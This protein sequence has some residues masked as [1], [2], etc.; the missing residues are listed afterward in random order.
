M[1]A[2]LNGS[3]VIA[4][5]SS[6]GPRGPEWVAVPDTVDI[7]WKLSGAVLADAPATDDATAPRRRI[8]S[9]IWTD[10]TAEIIE[11]QPLYAVTATRVQIVRALRAGGLE[12]AFKDGLAALP[13]DA[14][15]DWALAVEISSTD[16][17]ALAMGE[18]L[19][20]NVRDLFS[21]ATR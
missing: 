12:Q 1:Y 15:E 3:N 13:A 4:A 17:L 21:E 2:I 20:V 18:A 14:Q 16:P 9:G 8:V 7:G 11:A 19:G 5:L 10:R 6:A